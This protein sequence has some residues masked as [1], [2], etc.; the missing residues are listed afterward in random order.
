MIGIVLSLTTTLAEE[1]T[2]KEKK[3]KKRVVMENKF[4]LISQM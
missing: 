2:E 3:K 1:F 4:N